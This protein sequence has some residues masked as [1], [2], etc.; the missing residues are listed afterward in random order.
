MNRPRLE[1][2]A[3]V[4]AALW[5]ELERAPRDKHH[6]WRTCVLATVDGTG[7]DVRTEARADARTVV[8]REVDA[9]ERTILI[10]TDARSPKAGQIAA[11]PSG[12]LVLWSP[13][14][15]WQLRL[16]VQL[17]LETDGLAVMSRW[18]RM[19]L[20]PGAQDYLS[21]MPP[22]TPLHPLEDEAARAFVEPKREGR[23][24]FGVIA[25]EVGA[26]DWLELSAQGHRRAS[27]DGGVARWLAP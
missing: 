15:S 20:T 25:A 1:T 12:L 18:A 5:Q 6:G 19:K 27:F 14:L 4:E 24:H 7:G 21:P 8:L 23:E 22:G 9:A 26:I 17:R 10:Y 13:S 11:H 3:E 16:Q 2:L